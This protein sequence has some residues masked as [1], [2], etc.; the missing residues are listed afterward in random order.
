VLETTIVKDGVIS[1]YDPRI[2]R[3]RSSVLLSSDQLAS[4]EP[5]PAAVP[6]RELIVRIE[7]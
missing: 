1:G 6:V 2:R 4:F 7:R 5:G 3:G